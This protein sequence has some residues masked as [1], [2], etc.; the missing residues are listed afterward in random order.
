M[1]PIDSPW[2]PEYPPGGGGGSGGG[3]GGEPEQPPPAQLPGLGAWLVRRYT[4]NVV[5]SEEMPVLD[6][7]HEVLFPAARMFVSQGANGKIR[8][9]NHKPVDWALGTQAFTGA[10]IGVDDV[11][12]WL[13]D[14][15]RF[16]LI[17]P[18]T[19][20]SEVRVVTGA[21][22]SEEHNDVTL[23][24]DAIFTITGFSGATG[25]TPA[26]ATVVVGAPTASTT[27]S[28]ALDGY[29]VELIAQADDTDET[30]A[31]FLKGTFEAHPG[32][33]RKF[34]FSVTTDTLTI[35]GRFGTLTLDAALTETHVAPL[36]DPVTAPTLAASAGALP[37]GVYYVSYTQVNSHGETLLSP[38]KEITLTAN[39]KIDVTTVALASGATAVRWYVVPEAGSVRFRYHTENDGSAFSINS[40]PLLTAA[41]P[42]DL[43]RTGTEVMRVAAVFSDRE[44]DRTSLTG[45]NVIRSS[46][47]WLLGNRKKSVNRIDLKYRDANQDWRLIELRLRD[48]AHIAKTK[49]V[50][51]EEINGQAIDNYFQAY[52]IA[53]G[54]LA[55]KRDADF[56]Y[57]WK[58]TRGANLLE[59]GDVVC[60]TDEGSG[61]V[62]L[63]VSIEE[64]SMEFPNASM[65]RVSFTGMKYSTTLYDDSVVER[66]IP[67]VSE[68]S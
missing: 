55:V 59:E 40:L 66:T 41:L 25:P 49:K 28:I 5:L 48:D 56:F 30:I 13:D 58:A 62:N 22:Y 54:E 20:Q 42:P 63:P 32:L 68:I 65:P 45:S 46:M 67:V 60:I 2:E 26:T 31:A 1:R 52:R 17:D 18:H 6:C 61:V 51:N 34:S 15:S 44:E 39:Q 16:L 50:Q 10:E 23:T 21:E 8:I 38:F 36:A 3:G 29:T 43:N 33:R 27:Y 24:G 19:A 37:A 64:I 57:K 7:L 47:E 53:A 35:T 12:P 11:S 14:Q 4:S 9:Q